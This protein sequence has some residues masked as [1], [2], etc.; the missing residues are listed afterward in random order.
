[1]KTNKC[2]MCGKNFECSLR[3]NYQ[4]I[5]IYKRKHCLECVPLGQK[6]PYYGSARYSKEDFCNAVKTSF[7]IREVLIKLGLKATG[8]AYLSFKRACIRFNVSTSHFTG[9]LWSKGKTVG[10]KRPVEDYLSGKCCISSDALKKRLIQEGILQHKCLFCQ[11]TEWN[12]KPIPIELDHIDGDH[13][14][15][16]LKNLRILCRNCHAQT[17]TYAGKNKKLKNSQS[18][19]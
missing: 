12:N 13:E 18:H 19:K 5:H 6:P 16:T 9:M 1:M 17:N 14:N 3:K 2:L 11:G 4:N 8:G 7:S 10:P 15:N